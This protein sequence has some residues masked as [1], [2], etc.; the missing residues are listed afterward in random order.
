MNQLTENKKLG[1]TD[2]IKATRNYNIQATHLEKQECLKTKH[3]KAWRQNIQEGLGIIAEYYKMV[4][5]TSNEVW[6]HKV[7]DSVTI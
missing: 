3:K 2:Y 7:M 6:R 4:D 1:T 5:V